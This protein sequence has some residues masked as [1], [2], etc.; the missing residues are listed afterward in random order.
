MILFL[1]PFDTV[2]AAWLRLGSS[3]TSL[4][5]HRL[6]TWLREH[7]FDGSDVLRPGC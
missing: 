5:L 3:G 6:C 4:V 2:G 1:N 7:G